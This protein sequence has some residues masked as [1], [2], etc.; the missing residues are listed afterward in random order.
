MFLRKQRGKRVLNEAELHALEKILDI[1]RS[2]GT[3]TKARYIMFT[4]L[5]EALPFGDLVEPKL[6]AFHSELRGMV[7]KW[8]RL[9]V[10]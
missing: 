10:K 6:L 1:C 4:M 3:G 9:K 2:E 7:D 8:P 5:N